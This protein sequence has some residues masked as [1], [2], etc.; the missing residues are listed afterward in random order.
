ML[1][2]NSPIND[3]KEYSEIRITEVEPIIKLNLRG[4]KRDFMTKIGKELS[5]IPPSDPNSSSGNEKFNILW[6]SP[7]EWMLYSNDKS[8]LNN[9]NLLEEKLFNEVSKSKILRQLIFRS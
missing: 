8:D 5:I 2:Y 1:N 4:K 3:Q 7:D 6:L 9:T